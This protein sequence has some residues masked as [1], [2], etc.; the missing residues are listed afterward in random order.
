MAPSKWTIK[1]LFLRKLNIVR[2]HPLWRSSR[3]RGWHTKYSYWHILQA[4]FPAFTAFCIIDGGYVG[5]FVPFILVPEWQMH[6]K[7]LKCINEMNTNRRKRSEVDNGWKIVTIR[8]LEWKWKLNGNWAKTGKRA[9]K[10]WCL[11][12]INSLLVHWQYILILSYA[13][14][15]W[16]NYPR[17]ISYTGHGWKCLKSEYLLGCAECSCALRTVHCRKESEVLPTFPPE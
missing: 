15:S 12:C 16:T 9:I 14:F 17:I 4:H 13:R 2:I 11:K 6:L 3:A 1:N 5:L 10:N 7:R 8:G